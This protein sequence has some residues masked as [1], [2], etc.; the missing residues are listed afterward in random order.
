MLGVGGLLA[1]AAAYC[2]LWL[3]AANALEAR[4]REVVAERQ[5]ENLTI[6]HGAIKRSGFPGVLTL[7]I[8]H[9]V[10][11]YRWRRGGRHIRHAY[12]A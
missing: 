4:F 6:S 10:Y 1:L 11:A 2:I 5:S 9:P 8:E 7:E 3:V 12:L